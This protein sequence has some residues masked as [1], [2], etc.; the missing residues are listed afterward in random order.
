MQNL[1]QPLTAKKSIPAETLL[2]LGRLNLKLHSR[3]PGIGSS[4]QKVR[5]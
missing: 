4:F 2:T 5:L 1:P 3:A